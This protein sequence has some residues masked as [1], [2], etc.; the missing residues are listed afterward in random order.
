MSDTSIKIKLDNRDVIDYNISEGETI[1]NVMSNVK[2]ENKVLSDTKIAKNLAEYVAAFVDNGKD[3]RAESV[4]VN[5]ETID[6]A[7]AMLLAGVDF[8]TVHYFLSQEPIIEFV[9]YYLN[10]GGNAQA[11]VKAKERFFPANYSFNFEDY[12]PNNYNLKDLQSMIGKQP[13][14]PVALLTDYLYYKQ[15]AKPIADFIMAIKAGENG[16]GPTMAHAIFRLDQIDQDSIDKVKGARTFL[17]DGSHM[18]GK[19]NSVLNYGIEFLVS[20]GKMIDVRAGIYDQ[21]KRELMTYKK[22]N[23]LTVDEI[24]ELNQTIM[25]YLISG[26]LKPDA[27]L[28]KETATML[29]AYKK[30]NPDNPYKPFLDRLFVDKGI[31]QYTGLGGMDNIELGRIRESWQR[32]LHDPDTAQLAQN[33][34]KYSFAKSGFRVSPS[35]FSSLQPVHFYRLDRELVDHINT[36]LGNLAHNSFPFIEQYIRHNYRKLGFI[37]SFNDPNSTETQV[38]D[39][40]VG[41]ET[42]EQY[43]AKEEKESGAI[44]I[45]YSNVQDGKLTENSRVYKLMVNNKTNMKHLDDTGTPL[46]YV[47]FNVAIEVTDENGR[48]RTVRDVQLFRYVPNTSSEV[49]AVYRPEQPLGFY[50]T[51]GVVKGMMLEEY[52]YGVVNLDSQYGNNVTELQRLFAEDT[53]IK[54]AA[55]PMPEEQ[56]TGEN[57]SSRESEL[58]KTEKDNLTNNQTPLD[59]PCG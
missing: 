58:G 6:V 44:V 2:T 32:M 53:S 43:Q 7:T 28:I 45:K 56:I 33:L 35:S 36:Q 14:N 23:L 18:Q 41:Q 54:D 31:I 24:T 51:D 37:P 16:V 30:A 3:P 27:K 34:I 12:T 1:A 39:V 4:N 13:S 9:Q 11:L 21:V 15:Q 25:D 19:I 55:S 22:G 26:Q 47:K 20:K 29:E 50:R 46:K 40:P 38:D 17:N 8:R 49:F 10:M 5:S 42:Y 52:E 57:I 59:K 48:S